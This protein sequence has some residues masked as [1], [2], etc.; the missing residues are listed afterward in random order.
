MYK[1]WYY[2]VI[3][4]DMMVGDKSMAL[5]CKEYNFDKTIVDSGTTTIH[6]PR[7]VFTRL[8]QSIQHSLQVIK[9]SG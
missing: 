8:V 6:L 1:E 4:T 9:A 7:A 3:I 2:E 5:D